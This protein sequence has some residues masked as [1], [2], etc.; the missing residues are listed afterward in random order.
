MSKLRRGIS[1]IFVTL[2]LLIAVISLDS[3]SEAKTSSD[4]FIIDFRINV[5][6][7]LGWRVDTPDPRPIIPGIEYTINLMAI[8]DMDSS[9][10]SEIMYGYLPPEFARY[11]LLI[12]C[13]CYDSIKL[14]AKEV[15]ELPIVF[16][17][18]PA[19]LKDKKFKKNK[20]ITVRFNFYP[21]IK[22]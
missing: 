21:Q 11:F 15:A 8:N 10:I 18:D 9:K 17:I 5:S 3:Y 19:I 1:A 2:M 12:E 4:K 14:R 16:V 13:F 7:G 20:N 22:R 6:Y